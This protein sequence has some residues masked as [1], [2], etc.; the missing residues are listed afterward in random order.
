MKR[1]VVQM[2]AIGEKQNLCVL[3]DDG[4]LW[5][6]VITCTQANGHKTFDAQWK[7]MPALPENTGN[8]TKVSP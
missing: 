8:L 6:R 7:P 2:C 4:S 5:V 1:K 3:A